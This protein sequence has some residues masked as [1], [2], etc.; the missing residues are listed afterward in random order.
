MGFHLCGAYIK[1]NARRY[2]LLDSQ[3]NEES[4]TQGIKKVNLDQISWVREQVN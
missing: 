1:N 3:D 4:T 2:G